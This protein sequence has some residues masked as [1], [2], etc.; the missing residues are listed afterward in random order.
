MLLLPWLIE[1]FFS[2]IK[3]FRL[4]VDSYDKLGRSYVDFLNLSPHS[5]FA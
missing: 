1:R 3:Q 4:V 5:N 2:K